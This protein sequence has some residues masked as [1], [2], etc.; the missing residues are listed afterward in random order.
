MKSIHWTVSAVAMTISSAERGPWG[1]DAR[2]DVPGGAC[3]DDSL[4]AGGGT[5]GEY[6]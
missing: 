3:I 1:G 2:G 5:R 6:L 4:R